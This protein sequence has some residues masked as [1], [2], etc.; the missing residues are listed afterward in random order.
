MAIVEGVKR[1]CC[2]WKKMSDTM[3]WSA[4]DVETDH[5]ADVA[6]QVIQAVKLDGF[7]QQQPHR[8]S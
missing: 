6:K 2:K 8:S 1:D 7:V 5:H 3:H 4:D